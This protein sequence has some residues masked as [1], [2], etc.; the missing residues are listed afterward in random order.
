MQAGAL[1]RAVL[2]SLHGPGVDTLDRVLF[3]TIQEDARPRETAL[4]TVR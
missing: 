1:A 2:V 3:R 4:S